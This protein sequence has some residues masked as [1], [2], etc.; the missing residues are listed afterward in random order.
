MKNK[1]TDNI[2]NYNTILDQLIQIYNNLNKIKKVE[3]KLY[4]LK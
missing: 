1:I 3:D 4:K 2:Y